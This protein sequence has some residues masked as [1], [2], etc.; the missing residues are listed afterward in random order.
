[1][2]QPDPSSLGPQVQ[3][4]AVP[5]RDGGGCGSR[6]IPAVPLRG[7]ARERQPCPSPPPAPPCGCPPASKTCW[8]GW[9]WRCC[10][11]SPPM[12]WPL[13]LSTSKRCWSRERVSGPAQQHPSLHLHPLA[14]AALPAC[15]VWHHACR[16]CLS[17]RVSL[18]PHVPIAR[19]IRPA[20]CAHQ[21]W[22]RAFPECPSP[23]ASLLP[24]APITQGVTPTPCAHRPWHCA[25]PMCPSPR[26][27]HLP[28]VPILEG[29]CTFPSCPSLV[30]PALPR[31]PILRG[32]KPP[33]S[34][35]SSAD[36]AVWG[37]RLEDQVL[38]QPL[39]QPGEDEEK[40]D[41]DKEEEKAAS[42]AGSVASTDTEG[43]CTKL[44]EDILDIPLDDPDANAAA[45][46]IQ[47]S[48]RGHM[49]RKK[50]KGGEIDR[51]TKDAECANSTRGSDLRNGD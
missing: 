3:V 1:M 29:L 26:A 30:P 45:A 9:H 4:P 13:P 8:R 51:K 33:P 31:V 48:F 17:P 38:T 22:H 28:L 14:H 5:G 46:K 24:H 41:K 23:R 6:L 25:C 44:D 47:A 34:P 43:A 15:P 7:G 12:W 36:L 37:A 20:P 32:I 19:G 21:P 40:E 42:Q 39:F 50:I 11:H 2:H 27:P 16:A 35:D 49:T 18:L 10:G